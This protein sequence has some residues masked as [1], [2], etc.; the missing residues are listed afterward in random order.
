MKLM[1]SSNDNGHSKAGARERLTQLQIGLLI[2]EIVLAVIALVLATISIVNG[3][4][5]Q[6]RVDDAERAVSKMEAEL[7][8]ADTKLA[9]TSAEARRLESTVFDLQETLSKLDVFTIEGRIRSLQDA[10]DSIEADVKRAG[11]ISEKIGLLQIQSAEAS[12]KLAELDREVGF[13][14]WN[15]VDSTGTPE[16]FSWFG[17]ADLSGRIPPIALPASVPSTAT[18]VYLSFYII[19]GSDCGNVRGFFTIFASEGGKEFRH[20][21]HH[22]SYGANALNSFSTSFT[23]PVTS[24]RMVRLVRPPGLTSHCGAQVRFG[25][26]GWR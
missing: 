8:V 14:S 17:D 25:V 26:V 10:A 1:D 3:A 13:P 24:D 23:L 11:N 7:L 16:W 20:I 6:Q 18:T 9:L 19:S 15:Y 21:F 22:E 5:L 4:D 2:G 12:N